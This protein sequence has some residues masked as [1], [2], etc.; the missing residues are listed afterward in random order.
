M[1][2]LKGVGVSPGL[3]AGRAVGGVL[4]EL[5]VGG[6]EPVA[7]LDELD[8]LKNTLIV[9]AADHAAT[10]QVKNGKNLHAAC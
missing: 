6:P 7:Q 2:R 10:H 1:Q 9:I 3:G 4:G 5:P 8:M